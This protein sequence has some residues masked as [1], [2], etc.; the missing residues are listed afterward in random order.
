[1][2]LFSMFFL[3]LKT[4]IS[5]QF[6]N[7]SSMLSPKVMLIFYFPSNFSFRIILCIFKTYLEVQKTISGNSKY[8]LLGSTI[9]QILPHLVHLLLFLFFHVLKSFKV[10]SSHH[11]ILPCVLLLFHHYAVHLSQHQGLIIHDS[12]GISNNIIM[13]PWCYYPT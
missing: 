13:K 1:M 2:N 11:V 6:S 9:I 3:C 5:R 12:K 10:K 4:N 8:H 7:V